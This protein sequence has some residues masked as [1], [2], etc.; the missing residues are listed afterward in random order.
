MKQA[1]II[2]HGP[3][4]EALIEAAHSIIGADDGLH[5]INVTGMSLNEINDRLLSIVNVPDEKT[6]GIVI[7]ACLKGGS[8]WNVAAGIAMN[9]NKV[10][11]I[12]GVNLPMLL[13]YM[14]KKDLLPL[15]K[16]MDEMEKDGVR[17]IIKL[18]PGVKK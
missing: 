1:V 6:E 8:C 4:G 10:R 2:T 9:K 12:S 5:A 7:M 17:G 14:T 3:I 18:E 11:V 13:S 15:D 16:L